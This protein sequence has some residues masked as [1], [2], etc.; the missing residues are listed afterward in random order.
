MGVKEETEGCRSVIF[1]CDKS[2]PHVLFIHLSADHPQRVMC[3]SK[4]WAGEGED[5]VQ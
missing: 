4:F 2:L 3:C 5:N 1:V